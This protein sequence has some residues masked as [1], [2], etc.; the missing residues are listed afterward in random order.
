MCLGALKEK[1]NIF[2]SLQT[3]TN[4]AIQLPKVTTFTALEEEKMEA[5]LSSPFVRSETNVLTREDVMLFLHA[6]LR[7]EDP[8]R[9]PLG[10]M[11]LLEELLFFLKEESMV[12]VREQQQ[13][14]ESKEDRE[15]EQEQTFW[16]GQSSLWAELGEVFN[17]AFV[18]A[19]RIGYLKVM[20]KILDFF[21]FFARSS[22]H[23][24]IPSSVLTNIWDQ[25]LLRAVTDKERDMLF[26]WFL[27]M[28]VAREDKSSGMTVSPIEEGSDTLQLILSRFTPELA[29]HPHLS[30]T[31][32]FRTML[33]FW[34]S[35]N[36]TTSHVIEL[37]PKGYQLLLSEQ[38]QD[39]GWSG[40][41]QFWSFLL[42][43]P[44][45]E[46][47]HAAANFLSSLASHIA[48]KKVKNVMRR[49]ILSQTMDRVR[50]ECAAEDIDW[51]VLSRL[52]SVIEMV[53]KESTVD[54]QGSF[55]SHSARMRGREIEVK[56]NFNLPSVHMEKHFPTDPK[57]KSAMIK[58]YEGVSVNE[59][60]GMIAVAL[61][62]P[63]SAIKLFAKGKEFSGE[64]TV[65]E[66]GMKQGEA[67]MMTL[68]P[69]MGSLI[70][71][72][73]RNED[74]D[75]TNV[76]AGDMQEEEDDQQD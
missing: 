9:F 1:T 35:L 24:A 46:V 51:Q 21:Q 40:L 8:Q 33:R 6:K 52:F 67:L 44:S 22:P 43:S 7:E 73:A 57:Q 5:D 63:P 76:S 74:L 68:R 65:S 10:M 31:P 19:S 12:W 70:E 16:M 61:F 18:A 4:I 14:L 39:W 37:P 26:Q 11:S 36:A 55:R 69:N 29:R 48:S 27:R 17:G 64:K 13:E 72:A 41:D 32:C 34:L 71:D 38:E 3:I 20:E 42:L 60:I 56:V 62:V 15:E 50:Q 47:S 49:S 75:G 2:P 59:A 28:V 30:C 45:S 66:W 53:L 25:V 23:L 58:L 54:K